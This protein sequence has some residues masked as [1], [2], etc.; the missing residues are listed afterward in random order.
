MTARGCL[1]G[2]LPLHHQLSEVFQVSFNL[3]CSSKISVT[4]DKGPTQQSCLCF[5]LKNLTQK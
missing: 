3:L 2:S 5:I 1:R 4:V